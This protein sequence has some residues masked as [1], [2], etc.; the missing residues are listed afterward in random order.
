MSN[1]SSAVVS[2]IAIAVLSG[3]SVAGF[4]L[5]TDVQLLKV[6]NVAIERTMSEREETTKRFTDMMHQMDRTLAVQIEAV[7]TLK[8][9]VERLEGG[10][11]IAINYQ[12]PKDDSRD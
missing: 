10:N 1:G 9:A 3:A 11:F 2:G 4:N 6:Q 7:N 8:K 5:Y 12:E